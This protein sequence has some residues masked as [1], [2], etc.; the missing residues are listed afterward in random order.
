VNY[1][2]DIELTRY[3]FWQIM[4]TMSGTDVFPT[5]SSGYEHVRAENDRE[6]TEFAE[7]IDRAEDV[8]ELRSAWMECPLVDSTAAYVSQLLMRGLCRLR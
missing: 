4:R 6:L 3:A 1:S 5:I 7:K 2:T 8:V